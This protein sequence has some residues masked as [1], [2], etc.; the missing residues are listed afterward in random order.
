M[1]I[2]VAL[3]F[4]MLL[5][6]PGAWCDEQPV[7]EALAPKVQFEGDVNGV[8][9]HDEASFHAAA[10]ASWETKKQE[11]IDK[12]TKGGYVVGLN[13]VEYGTEEA[14]AQRDYEN[15]MSYVGANGIPTTFGDGNGN[16]LSRE[17]FME[18]NRESFAK[19][20]AQN[21]RTMKEMLAAGVDPSDTEYQKAVEANRMFDSRVSEIADELGTMKPFAS[22]ESDP[23]VTVLKP[24]VVGGMNAN[25]PQITVLNNMGMRN[26]LASETGSTTSQ[27]PTALAKHG[28]GLSRHDRKAEI[29]EVIKKPENEA[30]ARKPRVLVA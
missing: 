30:I 8:K 17:E 21:E 28:M 22:S 7:A 4:F 11:E 19:M 12:A 5:S 14:F 9:Y 27:P 25:K 6:V 29:E 2:A 10:D 1:K 26:T 13:G 3:L 16:L 23:R 20:K 24:S 15:S 18:R